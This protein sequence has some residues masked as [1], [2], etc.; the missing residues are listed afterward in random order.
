MNLNS[1]T[2]KC[3][4]LISVNFE[5]SPNTSAGRQQT[6]KVMNRMNNNGENYNEYF[7]VLIFA[8]SIVKRVTLNIVMCN[9]PD[10]HHLNTLLMIFG[11]G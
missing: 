2:N 5:A 4:C 10:D 6:I 7:Y 9:H 3:F 1:K 11:F 8:L